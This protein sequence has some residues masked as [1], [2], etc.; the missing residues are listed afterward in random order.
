[1]AA[2]PKKE[3]LLIFRLQQWDSCVSRKMHHHDSLDQINRNVHVFL[4]VAFT[5]LVKFLLR[6]QFILKT[7]KNRSRKYFGT[8][9]FAE[10]LTS[11]LVIVL[12]AKIYVESFHCGR[13]RFPSWKRFQRSSFHGKIFC[14]FFPPKAGTFCSRAGQLKNRPIRGQGLDLH[15]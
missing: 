12:A 9:L 4:F 6:L 7:F 1:M 14:H 11:H 13:S 2:K 15:S 5:I 10:N 8:P 3:S